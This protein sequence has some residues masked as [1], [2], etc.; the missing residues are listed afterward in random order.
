M[1]GGVSPVVGGQ[2]VGVAVICI[3]AAEL[4]VGVELSVES[5]EVLSVGHGEG[6]VL[7]APL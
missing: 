3:G 1:V 6:I 7:Q 5:D 2:V 4:G